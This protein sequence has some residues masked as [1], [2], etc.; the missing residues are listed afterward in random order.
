MVAV[1]SALGVATCAAFEA[2]PA[3]FP[4]SVETAVLPASGAAPAEGCSRFADIF[5]CAA[6]SLG[7]AAAEIEKAAESQRRLK[8]MPS[9]AAANQRRLRVIPLRDLYSIVPLVRVRPWAGLDTGSWHLRTRAN[10]AKTKPILRVLPR[11]HSP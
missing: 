2:A 10:P 4:E 6:A 5:F 9:R 7:E 3:A 11:C 8:V 1:A